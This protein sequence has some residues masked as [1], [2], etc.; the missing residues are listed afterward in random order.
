VLL[1]ALCVSSPV[2]AGTESGKPDLVAPQKRSPESRLSDGR[3]AYERGDY[4]AAVQTL[5]PLLYPS[6]ELSTEDAVIEAHRL[7]AL[8]YILQKKETQAE[9]EATS[10][11]ALR[12]SFQ[13]DP[14]VDPPT[15]VA[16][17]ETVRRRQSDRLREA[18]E[19]ERRQAEARARAED[20][21]RRTLEEQRRRAAEAPYR[22]GLPRNRLVAT[23]PFGVGQ[24]QNGQPRKA[25]LFLSSELVFGFAS[26]GGWLALEQKYPVDPMTSKRY[27][28]GDERTTAQALVGLQL[29]AGVA[30]WATLIWGVIDAHVL[31]KR[32]LTPKRRDATLR[33][34]TPS[35]VIAPGQLGFGV[36]GAF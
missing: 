5:V 13:L 28:P 31:F 19:R 32:Q 18:R 21:Q 30:F 34:L 12:P 35:T 22:S 6:I 23:I 14:I 4:A 36:Q 10:I 8:S 3:I 17:F 9:E 29:G 27:Y 26:L 11:L 2:H 24:W 33:S 1:F 25:A 16:F 7:L 15:A 20:E